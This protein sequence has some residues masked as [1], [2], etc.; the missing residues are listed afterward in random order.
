MEDQKAYDKILII[1]TASIGDVILA[2]SLVET[3]YAWHP[4]IRIDFLVKEGCEGVLQ[5]NPHLH[6]ILLWKKKERKYRELIAL[7]QKI[8]HERYDAVVNVHRFASSGFLTAFSKARIRSGFSKNPWS[9]FF[10]HRAPH[11]I[12]KDGMQHEIERNQKLIRFTGAETPS[13]PKVYPSFADFELTKIYKNTPYITIAP[14]SL[15]FTKQFPE[16]R[17]I[18]LIRAIPAPIHIYLLGS[19]SDKEATDRIALQAN[20]ERCINLASK[21]SL[22][23]TAALMRDARMNFTNDSAPLHLAGAVDAA[24]TAIFCSTVPAFGFGPLG[25]HALVIE[26]EQALAC[27]P[28]GLHGLKSC[29]ENTMACANTISL[30]KLTERIPYE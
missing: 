14:M 28:C 5:N 12:G 9:L 2:T 1:Q 30:Q 18:E 3:L 26:T 21:L 8:R 23:Q 16:S 7:A 19:A 10:N 6:S 25:D 13:R 22:L 11:Y 20:N 15:W 17:W 29:P 4:G 24:L 27:R